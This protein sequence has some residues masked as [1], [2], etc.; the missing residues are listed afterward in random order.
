MNKSVEIKC[1]NPDCG[2][3]FS[4]PM[5]FGDMNSFDSSTL[6]N[7]KVDC[8]YCRTITG[9]DKENMRIKGDDGGFRGDDTV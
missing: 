2:K 6:K 9:C 3:W 8:P 5:F 4:S 7:N 1:T